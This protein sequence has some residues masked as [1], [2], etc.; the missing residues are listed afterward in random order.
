MNVEI[1]S[2]AAL[3]PEKEYINGIYFP[4]SVDGG[5]FT[6]RISLI[7]S[8]AIKDLTTQFLREVF[9]S[10]FLHKVCMER[11]SDLYFG[12]TCKKEMSAKKLQ[13]LLG[14]DFIK[15]KIVYKKCGNNT[16]VKT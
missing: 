15:G 3:F 11:F 8:K 14:M 1:G 12:K 13:N 2:E 5:A 16:V 6:N 10:F 9:T 7:I 4:C